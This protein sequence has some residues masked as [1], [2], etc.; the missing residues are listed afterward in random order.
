LGEEFTKGRLADW[1]PS[2]RRT[3]YASEPLQTRLDLR[4]FSSDCTTLRSCLRLR[5]A[6]PIGTDAATRGYGLRQGGARS[7]IWERHVSRPQLHLGWRTMF[8][9]DGTQSLATACVWHMP[10][11]S[12]A[13]FEIQAGHSLASFALPEQSGKDRPNWIQRLAQRVEL[14]D[15]VGLIHR[16]DQPQRRPGWRMDCVARLRVRSCRN[17]HSAKV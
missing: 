1:E 11:G 10:V 14:V 7:D 9:M 8:A 12:E 16:G 13:M 15:L 5:C 2:I 6:A 3:R 17:H 4:S